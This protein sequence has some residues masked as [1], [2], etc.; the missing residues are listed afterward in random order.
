MHQKSPDLSS[1]QYT[2][3]ALSQRSPSLKS[4]GDDLSLGGENSDRSDLI[5][6]RW[7]Q[8][9]SECMDGGWTV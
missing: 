2:K 4:L 1:N 5:F 7:C 8:P 9:F 6:L 3:I